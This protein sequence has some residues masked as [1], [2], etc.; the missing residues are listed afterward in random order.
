MHV[1]ENKR[2]P[3]KHADIA[4]MEFKAVKQFRG[5]THDERVRKAHAAIDR[6]RPIHVLAVEALAKSK[7]ELVAMVRNDFDTMAPL[8]MAFAEA[9]DTARA[10]MEILGS[11]EVR[12]ATALANV[13]PDPD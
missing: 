5:L 11:A 2:T 4:S 8:L 13:E 6:I 9:K 1:V 3:A 7:P 12:L 10:V